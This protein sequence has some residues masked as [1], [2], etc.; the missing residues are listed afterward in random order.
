MDHYWLR[1]PSQELRHF[2]INTNLLISNFLRA[3][4]SDKMRQGAHLGCY[5][6][7]NCTGVRRA[8]KNA[9]SNY[10]KFW[11]ILKDQCREIIENFPE[12]IESFHHI[13]EGQ[14][15]ERCKGI[16]CLWRYRSQFWDKTVWPQP[17]VID[18]FQVSGNLT[19]VTPTPEWNI[20]LLWNKIIKL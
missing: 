10:G 17:S 15:R 19:G 1:V 11:Q 13:S 12:I 9:T 2:S 3:F 14:P 7:T 20:K 4:V 16:E 8:W 5:A 6:T 18:I